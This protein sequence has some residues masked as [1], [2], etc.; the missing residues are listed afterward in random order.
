MCSKINLFEKKKNHKLI[1]IYSY[2]VNI[3]REREIERTVWEIWNVFV[4][5]ILIILIFLFLDKKEEK[6]N[7]K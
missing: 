6:I 1:F 3:K 7:S 5:N 4:N 2:H